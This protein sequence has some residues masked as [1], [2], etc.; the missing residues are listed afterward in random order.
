MKIRVGY[1]LGVN[2]LTNDQD[3]YGPFVDALER[4]DY[5]SL[6]VSERIAGHSADPVVSMA[7]AAGRTKKLKFGMSVMVL[8][9]RN[10]VLVAKSIYDAGILGPLGDELAEAPGAPATVPVPPIGLHWSASTVDAAARVRPVSSSITC[11]TRCLLE[12]NTARRGR[13]AVPVD[14]TCG[15]GCGGGPA[16]RGG[17][18]TSSS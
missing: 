5:D 8:S 6:W 4:L 2:S 9:G 18:S 13:S 15:P 3:R 1:G 10:P 11:M 7:Y 16:L 14:A 12:R 17:S